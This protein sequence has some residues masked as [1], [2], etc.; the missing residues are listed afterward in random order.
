MLKL[1]GVRLLEQQSPEKP[2]SEPNTPQQINE[3][4]KEYQA[5]QRVAKTK[6]ESRFGNPRTRR[7]EN[8]QVANHVPERSQPI[9]FRSG[10]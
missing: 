10:T 3:S 1:R 4:P 2:K 9:S 8:A 7:S 6:Y 5:G